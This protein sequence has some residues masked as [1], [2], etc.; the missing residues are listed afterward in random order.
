MAFHYKGDKGYTPSPKLDRPDPRPDWYT[1]DITFQ[2]ME[3]KQYRTEPLPGMPGPQAPKV[4]EVTAI[5]LFGVT[6]SG[7]SVLAHVH[8]FQ[9]YI[10]IQ[11]PPGWSSNHIEPFRRM[12]NSRCEGALQTPEAIVSIEEHP[13]TS[14]MHYHV[15]RDTPFLKIT[16]LMPGMVPRIRSILEGKGVM[17]GGGVEY[18]PL[19]QGPMEFMTYESNVLFELRFLVDLEIGGSN[20][21]T[22][23]A[24]TYRPKP[25]KTSLAQLEI[26]IAFDKLVP[27]ESVGEY[28]KIAPLRILSFDIECQ[29]RPGK[30]PEA[31]HDSVIQIASCVHIH[32]NPEPLTS[33]V[34]CLKKVSPIPGVELHCFEN[35]REMLLAWGE[36]FR[37][38]D[39]DVVTGYNIVNFDIP[40]LLDRARVLNAV[41]FPFLSRIRDL[42]TTMRSRT[43]QN[44]AHGR[45]E[46]QEIDMPGRVQVDLLVIMQHEHK[47][48][49]YSLNNVSQIFLGEQKEDVHHSIISDLQNG[50]EETRNRL[51]RYCFKDAKLPLRL[52]EKLMILINLVEMARVTGVPVAWLI[53]KG[54][55]IKVYSQILRKAQKCGLLF[56]TV[57][58]GGEQETYTGATVIEPTRG[59][60]NYPIA[61]LDFAS[62]YPS[63]MMA[64]NLC[65]STLLPRGAIKDS[66][67]VKD[68]DY[69]VTPS[70]DCFVTKERYHGI[71]PVIL[72]DLLGAR[73]AAKKAM[74]ES[75]DPME[76]AVYNG[77]QLALKISANSVYGFTGATVGKLPC[78]EISASVTSF[79]RAM[80][81]QTKQA[82]ESK[83]TVANGYKKDAKVVYGDTDSVMIN[84][85]GEDITTEEAMALGNEAAQEVTKMFPPPVK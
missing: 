54:Q 68:K 50:N 2:L 43:F 57:E 84:F 82:V 59:F 58:S 69:I 19:Y 38:I 52:M 40:Y 15:K 32:G 28:M 20:W 26:D 33:T 60:H 13:R 65:Y 11:A 81:E 24:G 12:L 85:G 61:T 45:R 27:H 39:P 56:P 42:P 73:K 70:G 3:A 79:G 63:I 25:N 21:I 83:Y 64:H 17:C 35:E 6:A 8:G 78:L 34:F 18:P 47:L 16:T 36:Y 44:K 4:K 71:L 14:L 10:W 22:C 31:E 1:K 53:D 30:F 23:P 77:R 75:K 48:R 29:G 80:I 41:R 7:V 67:L 72:Q 74:Q 9:P 55:Q 66:G 62:L 49:S 51:A 46:Y 76:V 37:A 5:W